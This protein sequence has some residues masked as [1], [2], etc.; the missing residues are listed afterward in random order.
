MQVK[1]C[2]LKYPKNLLEVA[3]LEP[4]FIGF[5]FY[6]KSKRFISRNVGYREISG[7]PKSVKKVGVFVNE[8]MEV[9]EMMARLYQ[10]DY[11]QLHGDEGPSYCKEL[12]EKGFKLIKAFGIESE[13]DNEFLKPYVPFC[14][15]FLFD[16]KGMLRGGN[17]I[18]FN[19]SILDTYQLETPFILSGGIDL[20]DINAIQSISHDRLVAVDINSRFE[21]NPGLKNIQELKIFLKE[22]QTKKQLVK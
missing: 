7:I 16:T 17:G 20:D 9:L 5:I 19:W 15:Y 3:S 21:K 8:H 4:D 6:E 18:K 10:L 14:E 11:I 13:V 2:G 1:I 12:S 22:V